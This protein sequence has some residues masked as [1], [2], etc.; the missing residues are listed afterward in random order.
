VQFA[1]P[2]TSTMQPDPSASDWTA[3]VPSNGEISGMI[4]FDGTIPSDARTARLTFTQIF[5]SLKGPRSIA[6][7][8]S[9][10]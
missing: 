4:V 2:G 5:G 7:E 3:Q 6:V 9:L 1:A 8:I 10:N